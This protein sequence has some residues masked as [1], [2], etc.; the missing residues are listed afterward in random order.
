VIEAGPKYFEGTVEKVSAA[1]RSAG[2]ALT[3][4]EAKPYR[5][6]RAK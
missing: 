4:R 6:A 1:V 3:Q 5:Q 2:A